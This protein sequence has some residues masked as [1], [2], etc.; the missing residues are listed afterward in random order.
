MLYPIRDSLNLWMMDSDGANPIKLTNNDND[1]DFAEWSP[2]GQLL[3][4]ISIGSN[5]ERLYTMRVGSPASN[6]LIYSGTINSFAWSPKG[7]YI[8]LVVPHLDSFLLR[9]IWLLRIDNLEPSLLIGEQRVSSFSG[10]VWAPKGNEFLFEVNCDDTPGSNVALW[11]LKLDTKH[12]LDLTGCNSGHNV[13]PSWSPNGDRI[14]FQSDRSGDS[15]IWTMNADG[16][17]PIDLTSS[18][19]KE[20]QIFTQ[21][22]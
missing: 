1:N 14:A 21:Y 15:D 8:L 16:S 3:A 7:D 22:I 11:A 10:L 18:N 4:F 17:N 6:R 19:E 2:D 9:D 13:D 12:A 5:G 20:K